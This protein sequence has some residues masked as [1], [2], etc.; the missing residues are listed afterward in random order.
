MLDRS[1]ARLITV[2]LV[3][4]TLSALIG[5]VVLTLADKAIPDVLAY[6]VSTGFGG[7]ATLST[8][9][10][11]NPNPPTTTVSEGP[12]VTLTGGDP[13]EPTEP[14]GTAVIVGKP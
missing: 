1:N 13:A 2:A 9:R 6:V 7:I 3:L 14:L 10:A 5:L 11:A 8:V 12:T 4:I